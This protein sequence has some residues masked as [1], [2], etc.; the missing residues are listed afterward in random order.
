[1]TIGPCGYPVP[2]NAIESRRIHWVGKFQWASGSGRRILKWHSVEYLA[3][4]GDKY[5]LLSPGAM[6]VD[7][8]WSMQ[9]TY[10]PDILGTF[11][12]L[13]WPTAPGRS[14]NPKPCVGPMRGYQKRACSQKI[15]WGLGVVYPGGLLL[16]VFKKDQTILNP[17]RCSEA[18]RCVMAS[19]IGVQRLWRPGVCC[20]QQLQTARWFKTDWP[21]PRVR[22]K[23]LP[24]EN[25]FGRVCRIQTTFPRTVDRVRRSPPQPL[26]PLT[27]WK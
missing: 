26:P 9:S 14:R 19:R 15:S 10:S 11:Q 12:R 4:L 21:H 18:T 22:N 24:L 16:P 25:R 8:V 17:M 6:L 13:Q 20:S 2:R 27:C 3:D 23:P 1:M 7:Y 5:R